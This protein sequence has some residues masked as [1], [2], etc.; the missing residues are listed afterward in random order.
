MRRLAEGAPELA[1]E[2]GAREA[3]RPGQVVDPERLEVA[4]V[5]Q[6]LGA[7]QMAGGRDERHPR[8]LG[9]RP[10]DRDL[11]SGAGGL[12]RV[13][14]DRPGGDRALRRR[15]AGPG[16]SPAVG[17]ALLCA[18]CWGT[19]R[20]PGDGVVSAIVVLVA[21]RRLGRL[22]PGTARG[23]GGGAARR[24]AGGAG[25]AARGLA[26]VRGR[27]PLRD[28]RHQLQPRHVPAPAGRRPARPR[29]TAPSSCTRATRS[30][31]TRSSS[32]S[33]RASAS[34]WSRASAASP[35]PSRSSPRS[36]RSP[37]SR[38]SG[39]SRAP[40]APW[41]SASPTSS[42]PTSPRAPSRRRSQALFVLAF[43]LALRE[44]TRTWRDLPL[45]FVPA[46]LLAVGSVYAYSFPG[47]IWLVGAAVIWA[48]VESPSAGW[49]LR[50]AWG[51]GPR[52]AERV[53]AEHRG[54]CRPTGPAVVRSVLLAFSPS[55]SS[56]PPR[57]AG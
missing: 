47:L 28:P 7:Q 45:R 11:C 24:L 18:V 42:P 49:R 21:R 46:A 16:S 6:V 44:S 51:G 54:A 31:R 55:P 32:P 14:G 4:G 57:S 25:R 36:P 15:G 10:C 29:R 1:A 5:G 17:L 34:A 27:R 33:T 53:R 8:S 38:T 12:R 26:A 13:A 50:V 39:R 35:S 37:P 20:L 19:V 48:L 22:P 9:S 3:R 43:V 41:S 23:R 2:V 56:S 30:A 52:G 40:P